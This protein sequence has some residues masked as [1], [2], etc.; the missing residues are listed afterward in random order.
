MTTNDIIC[1]DAIAELLKLPERSAQLIIADP[2]YFQV[3]Q[4]EEWDNQW[5]S[6]DDYLEWSIRW[7]RAAAR[8]LKDDGLFYIF[9]QLGKREHIWLHFCSLVAKELQ[10]HDMIIWDRAVGYN[11]RYDSFTPCYEMILA[12][13]KSTD[14]KPYF[15]KDAVRLPYEEEKIRAYL[16]DKRYKDKTARLLHLEKGKYATNILRV[17]SLKGS[18]KEKA[19]HPSQKPEKLIEQL[20]LSSSRPNDVVLDPF[21]GSGTTAVVAERLERQWIGIE[22]NPN[23]IQ[24]AERRL[25]ELRAKK[26]AP[27]FKTISS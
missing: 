25:A 7:T 15:N 21:L 23:Y 24:I 9:G 27:L 5:K 13:R 18:S 14:A 10:F 19:G 11:E 20:I 16:R 2:P 26:E 8:T 3:L 4:G 12:L 17:P 6:E 22:I 1:G